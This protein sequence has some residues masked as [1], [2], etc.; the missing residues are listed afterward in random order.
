[1]EQNVE[2]PVPADDATS[3][4][5]QPPAD[6]PASEP[7]AV[8]EPV[9]V[10][11]PVAALEPVAASE[12]APDIEPPPAA[13]RPTTGTAVPGE[14]LTLWC[15]T[16]G[17]DAAGRVRLFLKVLE[18]VG[19]LHARGIT[20]GHLSPQ[21]VQVSADGAVVLCDLPLADAQGAAG[22][23]EGMHRDVA[24]L[25]ELFTELLAGL[26][27]PRG[28]ERVSQRAIGAAPEDAFTNVAEFASALQGFA[29]RQFPIAQRPNRSRL[30]QVWVVGVILTA[31]LLI[32]TSVSLLREPPPATLSSVATAPVAPSSTTDKPMATAP[33][34]AG[35]RGVMFGES[36]LAVLPL[37][38]LSEAH[39]QSAWADGLAIELIDL[40]THVPDLRVRSRDSSFA[41][42]DGAAALTEIARRLGVA[43]VLTGGVLR[44]DDRVRLSFS[45]LQASTGKVLWSETGDHAIADLFEV[46]EHVANAVMEALD[47]RL[48]DRPKVPAADRT[49][50]AGAYEAYLQGLQ[51]YDLRSTQR[52]R[53]AEAAFTR[54][55]QLDPLFAPAHTGMAL[56][57]VAIAGTT[58]SDADYAR[59]LA[60]ANRALHLA[61]DQAVAYVV[62]ARERME[63]QHDMAGAR[64][65]LE[66]ARAIGANDLEVMGAYATYLAATGQ[67]Q[68]AQQFRA[69]IAERNPV[70]ETATR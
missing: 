66:S 12:S 24:A 51:A 9:D 54:A 57:T 16:R 60:A 67:A 13:P 20:H 11:E 22:S 52:L 27:L 47:L 6:A 44:T 39:D 31:I 3:A 8:S 32:L 38:D 62:R 58:H 7:D 1:M 46:Q 42:R 70:A 14:P 65:D 59:A 55:A 19:G 18:A 36:T 28:L 5:A 69:R 53:S 50:S 40:F 61:P 23:M 4:A 17:L 30:A 45:L 21:T 33:P 49:R 43:N 29:R 2:E 35:A 64:R 25:A 10:S 34:L 56:A 26:P 41:L 48:L 37:E 15:D 68:E 63:H